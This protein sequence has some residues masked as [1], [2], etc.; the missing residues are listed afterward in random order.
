[1]L[2]RIKFIKYEVKSLEDLGFALIPDL[3]DGFP[4]LT[5]NYTNLTPRHDHA[6]GNGVRRLQVVGGCH[7]AYLGRIVLWNFKDFSHTCDGI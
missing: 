4:T 5:Y 2:A 6:Q 3:V 1:M 7:D